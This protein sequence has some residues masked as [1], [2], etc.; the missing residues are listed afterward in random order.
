MQDAERFRQTVA[1]FAAEKREATTLEVALAE[2]AE[3]SAA[4]Y[5]ALRANRD[6][7][8][9]ALAASEAEVNRLQRCLRV[10]RASVERNRPDVL[11]QIERAIA[12]ERL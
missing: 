12:G 6:Q 10:L 1:R 8:A 5:E 4:S 7:T 2:Q 3:R 9:A 11:A